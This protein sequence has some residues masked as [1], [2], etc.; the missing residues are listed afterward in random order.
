[1]PK[2]SEEQSRV[3]YNFQIKNYYDALNILNS[4]LNNNRKRS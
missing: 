2:V 4:I 3:I 1:M